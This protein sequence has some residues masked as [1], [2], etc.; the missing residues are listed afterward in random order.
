MAEI[1]KAVLDIECSPT[2]VPMCIY[3][4]V[5]N[6]ALERAPETINMGHQLYQT[7]WV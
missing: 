4:S 6:A 3:A 5:L 2:T 7:I 1:V